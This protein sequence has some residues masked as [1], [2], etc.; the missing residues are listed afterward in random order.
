MYTSAALAK[1]FGLEQYLDRSAELND[2]IFKLLLLQETIQLEK[3]RKKNR[4]APG[5]APVTVRRVAYGKFIAACSGDPKYRYAVETAL[6][7]STDTVAVFQRSR[8]AG[9]LRSMG[10]PEDKIA[11]FCETVTIDDDTHCMDQD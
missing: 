4:E 6:K 1:K 10:I 9:V 5:A 3:F 8:F 7:A 2:A 11:E